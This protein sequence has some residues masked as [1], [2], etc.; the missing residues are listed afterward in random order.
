VRGID[1]SHLCA[2]IQA[3]R[4]NQAIKVEYQ[5]LSNFAP[6]RHWMAPHTLAFN[7]S[8]WQ[9]RAWCFTHC[10]SKGFLLARIPGICD[11][12][13]GD[14]DANQDADWNTQATLVIGTH[15]G[16]SDAQKKVIALD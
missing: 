12:R 11:T 3:I 10:C 6:R 13:D 2:V 1:A 7:G 14:I 16:L 4:N 9:T 8:R 5:S 15:P